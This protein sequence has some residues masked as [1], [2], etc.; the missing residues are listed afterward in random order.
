MV[1]GTI[2]LGF[3][4]GLLFYLGAK[5]YANLA[6]ELT[7]TTLATS[8]GVG[9]PLFVMFTMFRGIAVRQKQFSRLGA[10]RF[11]QAALTVLAQ[12]IGWYWFG[13]QPIVLALGPAVGYALGSIPM[14]QKLHGGAT[15][16]GAVHRH[17]EFAIFTAPS[18]IFTLIG[19]QA[20]PILLAMLFN[21]TIAGFYGLTLR[22]LAAPLALV[23]QSIGQVLLQC[24]QR[25]ISQQTTYSDNIPTVFPS[26]HVP[27]DSHIQCVVFL[28][29]GSVFIGAR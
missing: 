21:T 12:G 2:G 25:G 4:V 11:L 14:L 17:K 29:R 5:N 8:V 16:R 28:R 10:T 19:T 20:P 18:S 1:Q 15:F 6:N 27:I 13:A 26:T 23:G 24:R 22:L 9:M 3:V 7:Y